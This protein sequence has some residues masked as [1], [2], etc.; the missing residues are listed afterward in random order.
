MLV[1]R[2]KVPTNYVLPVFYKTVKFNWYYESEGDL[3]KA[4]RQL[5]AMN[6]AFRPSYPIVY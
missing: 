1:K 4:Y 2:S 3:F 6:G 5:K